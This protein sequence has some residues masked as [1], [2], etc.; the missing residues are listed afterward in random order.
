MGSAPS[1][2]APGRNQV[3]PYDSQALKEDTARL[4]KQLEEVMANFAKTLE[5][6]AISERKRADDEAAAQRARLDE[7]SAV[8][9]K[10]LD[11]SAAL[12]REK[13]DEAAAAERRVAA[14]QEEEAAAAERKRLDAEA[15]AAR[16]KLDQQAAD[17]RKELEQLA[18][19]MRKELDDAAAAQRQRQ[20]QEA[21]AQRQRLD[22]EAAA[23]RAALDAAAATER[24]QLHSAVQAT[25]E[26]LET[27][28][29]GVSSGAAS[30]GVQPQ[31]QQKAGA[32]V[33]AA[34]AA[35]S[36]EADDA[37]AAQ[38]QRL[39]DEAAAKRAAL[40][41]AAATERAQL[42]SAVQATLE[43]LETLVAGVS[44]GAASEGVQ[45]Q[46]QQK[47]GA[48]VG[49]ASAAAS[50]EADD[51][52]AAQ[53]QRLDDEAAAKRAA[54]DAAAATERAQLHS[55]VQ[56]TL[57]RLETLVAGV[58]SGAA[59]EGVQ[60]QPQQKAG[61][62][63]AAASAAASAEAEA[64][65]EERRKLQQEMQQLEQQRQAVAAAQAAAAAAAAAADLLCRILAHGVPLD[66]LPESLRDLH[67]GMPAALRE[68]PMRLLHIDSVMG[69]SNI[70]V[71]EEVD[72]SSECIEVPYGSV[73][74]GV[75]DGTLI[76]SW[77][78]AA[79][80][81]TQ[82]IEGF[83]PMSELQYG[84]LQRVMQ[85]AKAAGMSYVWIDWC[86]VPQYVGSPMVEVLR[87]KVFYARA[88]SMTVIPT[89]F[90]IPADGI[91]RLLLVKASRVIKRRA[92]TSPRAAV[93]ASRLDD[94]LQKEV[95][96]GREYF[97]RVWTLA[98]RM[99]R[100]G[101]RE[102]LCHW[103][104]LEAWL[105]MLVD[106]LLKSTDDRSALAIFKQI[107]GEQA[108]G[109]LEVVLDPLSE[110]VK[111]GSMHVSE[112]LDE[113]VADL[114]ESAVAT[115]HAAKGLEEAPTRE[116]LQTY[117]SQAHSGMYQAWSDAD[118][119]WSVYSYFCWK[120]LDQ[121]KEAALLEALQDLVRV[122]G[123]SRKHL[124]GMA[125]R[126]GLAKQLP[127]SDVD[128][129]LVAAARTNDTEA[130]LA[131][132]AEGGYPDTRPSDGMTALHHAATHG[133]VE[134][135]QALLAEGAS[136]GIRDASSATALHAAAAT[137]RAEVLKLL[138]AAPAGKK[139]L[140]VTG[141]EG[142]TPLAAAAQNGHEEVVRLLLAAGAKRDAVNDA[143]EIPVSLACKEG[144][145][146]VV[147]ALLD[148]GANPN[149]KYQGQTLLY[150]AMRNNHLDVL[151][152]LL[153]AGADKDMKNDNGFCTIS[154]A[155]ELNKPEVLKYLISVGTNIHPT[156]PSKVNNTLLHRAAFGNACEAVQVLID[157]GFDK[158]ARDGDCR[159]TALS[160]AA[161][162]NNVAVMKVLIANKVNI[163][164]KD[165]DLYTAV[166]YAAT[167]NKYEACVFLINAG[168][169]L[170]VKT[171]KGHTP[172]ELGDERRIKD[173]FPKTMISLF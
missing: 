164:S 57:E 111:T 75:W 16:M 99:A 71:Y 122:A 97:S 39:D 62:A 54:L 142:N 8:E 171:K 141:K 58:S 173:L 151:K 165:K 101:R 114:F 56:A 133:N 98:E 83:S 117:L 157:A 138:L 170:K 1:Q 159:W 72:T 44:S 127:A 167:C 145:A 116:W 96:A 137:G 2:E 9:R 103:L 23:K 21:A 69:W 130:L 106:A 19:V 59:S 153:S 87:S 89:F 150:I 48:A 45:P 17:H 11:D 37:A 120:Q 156:F 162:R 5:A 158:E 92:A 93:V 67:D 143:K 43:R 33:G 124:M 148:A 110:A 134:A 82:Y 107:L 104:S 13:L 32:A 38:R 30:E 14:A 20:D 169:N 100:L 78:W 160:T 128:S 66:D 95:V 15:K 34:S 35:A 52:A 118:R 119:V 70:K 49:A 24:A 61:A 85:R 55:A 47:A 25:L 40:D 86:C 4:R 22:D 18:A 166:C 84:E 113:L 42:H 139:D 12:A 152:T 140:E 123:G 7:S 27:L 163:E 94:I 26:R 90:P 129:K 74:D 6:T 46:P 112:G 155:A 50:A 131:V 121:S 144:H 108:A 125:T 41:A 149:F 64:L 79:Q 73:S 3:V 28:V 135:V 147:K 105:G 102:Q 31:P 115:W 136:Q 65:A 77:R 63:A 10:K 36:A 29:A 81:P 154:G 51:A 60:P 109:L 80:K 126:L 132:L 91:V 172:R 161:M 53:R 168:A 76:L 146:L 68:A 88:R